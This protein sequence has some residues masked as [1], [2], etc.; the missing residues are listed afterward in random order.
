MIPPLPAATAT[1][2]LH[3]TSPNATG[4]PIELRVVVDAEFAV[5]V[6]GTSRAN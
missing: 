6:P 1:G 5:G 2:V 3:I 4:P